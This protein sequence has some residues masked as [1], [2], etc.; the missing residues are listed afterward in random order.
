MS[1]LES[2]SA[3]PTVAELSLGGKLLPQGAALQERWA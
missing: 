3:R 2:Q 1:R